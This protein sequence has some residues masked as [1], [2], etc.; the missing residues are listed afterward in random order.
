MFSRQCSV[1]L[2]LV[3]RLVL[4]CQL[5]LWGGEVSGQR[6]A[7]TA[8]GLWPEWRKKSECRAC[9]DSGYG[10]TV[11]KLASSKALLCALV[12]KLMS[13]FPVFITRRAIWRLRSFDWHPLSSK[14]VPYSD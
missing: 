2:W 6:L 11:S 1:L 12:W 7:P 10:F 9:L 14:R 5:Q 3:L 13:G 8:Y 4:R